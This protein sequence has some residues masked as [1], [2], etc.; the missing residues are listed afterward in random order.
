LIAQRLEEL[1]EY[2]DC[3]LSSLINIAVVEPGDTLP[4]I[5]TEL[6]FSPAQ[7]PVDVI[8]SHP[9][10]YELTYVLADDGFGV[11][12]YVPKIPAIDETLKEVC[13]GS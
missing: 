12:L 11:V 2:D 13:A 5:E 6:G 9:S 3:D 8:E 4:Q 7:R 1:S 10:W